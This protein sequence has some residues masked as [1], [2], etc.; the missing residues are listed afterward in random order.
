MNDHQVTGVDIKTEEPQNCFEEKIAEKLDEKDSNGRRTLHLMPIRAE[1]SKFQYTPV[2]E[3]APLALTEELKARDL[4]VDLSA[5]LILCR[6][7]FVDTLVRSGVAR[8]L[9]FKMLSSS[10][11]CDQAAPFAPLR[12]PCSKAEVFKT[13]ALSLLEKRQLMKFLQYSMD[14]ATSE[15]N[16]GDV[17]AVEKKN[18][19][20]LNQGRS[21]SR[22]QNKK[23]DSFLLD[24]K[25]EGG[26]FLSFLEERCKLSPKLSNVVRFAVAL[27]HG[28]DQ[29]SYENGMQRVQ[30][31][32]QGIGRFGGTA[33]LYPMYGTGELAQAFTRMCA[34]NGGVYVLRQGVTHIIVTTTDTT[35][36]DADHDENTIS[37][38]RGIHLANGDVILTNQIVADPV[39]APRSI[40]EEKNDVQQLQRSVTLPHLF[41]CSEFQSI[42]NESINRYE[43]TKNGLCD[44][45]AASFDCRSTIQGRGFE[46]ITS[47][48][49]L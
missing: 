40:V 11:C 47:K 26:S 3:E 42:Q 7:D 29:V 18:E 24:N 48:I 21:L 45:V 16:K 44:Q 43:K 36:D 4:C 49:H 13:K 35:D 30:R 23:V 9:E 8:Y 20:M 32:L 34:V 17:S 12:V 10:N 38:V 37:D 39:Y 2:K 25:D 22:P 1:N 33:F 41:S 5:N 46:N 19:L 27:V 15:E 14:K 28:G 31:Y 6:G